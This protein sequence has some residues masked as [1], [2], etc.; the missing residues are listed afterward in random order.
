[1]KKG[2]VYIMMNKNR[3]VIYIGVTSDLKQRVAQHREGKGSAFT[4]KY[5]CH[6]L[7]Y[8]E[9]IPDMMQAIEREKKLKRWHREWKLNLIKSLN[10]GLKDLSE[11]I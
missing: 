1:M 3:T 6:Y 10:E 2:Y 9:I 8:Y 7:V 5:N 4:A 11:D